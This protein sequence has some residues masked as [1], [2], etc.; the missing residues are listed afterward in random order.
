MRI[1]DWTITEYGA[2]YMKIMHLIKYC[3]NEAVY[4]DND[5]GK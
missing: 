3:P 2:N 5:C 4:L 1:N